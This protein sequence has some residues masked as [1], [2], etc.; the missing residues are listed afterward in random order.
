[1]TKH[2]L[3]KHN[4]IL[5]GIIVYLITAVNSK[6]VYHADEQY[7]IIEFAGLKTG[8][9]SEKDLAWEF[10][11]EIRP[12]LQPTVCFIIF[13]V[14]KVFNITDPYDQALI[15]RILSAILA[16]ISITFFINVTS[17]QI[18]N[19]SLIPYYKL[20][21]YFLWFIPFIS[22][23]FSSETWAGLCFLLAISLYISHFKA[24]TKYIFTGILLGVSFLFRFQI[25]FA[26]LGFGLWMLIIDKQHIKKV[27]IIAIFGIITL[28]FGFLIDCWFYG[29][30]VFAPW[31]YFYIN[32]IEDAAS[33][34]G[35]SPWYFY[36]KEIIFR[37]TPYI[38]IPILL[39]F[40]LFIIK[41]PKS[42]VIWCI[43]PFL[44]IH[45][46]IP[47]KEDRFLFPMVFFIPFIIIQ[48]IDSFYSLKKFLLIRYSFYLISIIT[49]IVNIGGLLIISNKSAGYGHMEITEH[50]HENYKNDS[51]N[52]IYQ[53]YSNPYNPFMSLPI[54]HYYTEKIKETRIKNLLELNQNNIDTNKINFLVFYNDCLTANGSKENIISNHFILEKQGAPQWVFYINEYLKIFGTKYLLQLHKYK[55]E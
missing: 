26:V 24:S 23:R 54:K 35:T 21:S 5:I 11:K 52:L 55:N 4:L 28:S 44:I 36:L 18:Q 19:K 20:L 12:S 16:L 8:T 27:L 47:H 50:L 53:S 33:G 13:T 3:R 29:K 6:G 46:I 42:L 14:C 40:I 9:H 39:S 15:L 25:A 48:I 41:K 51:I 2:L 38:G 37:S 34:F 45:S 43:L 31:N 17:R 1:M 22:V 30:I 7:Q 32:I 49:F 10:K